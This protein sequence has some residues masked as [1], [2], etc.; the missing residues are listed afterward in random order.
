MLQANKLAVMSGRNWGVNP[1]LTRLWYKTVAERKICYAASTWAE[2]LNTKKIAQLSSIQRLFTLRIT[3]AYRTAPSSALLILSGLPPLHLTVKK[4]AI[5]TN[6]TRLGKNDKFGST[7]FNTIEYDTQISQW[8]EPPWSKPSTTLE[9]HL[10]S[11]NITI[12][13]DGSKIN[14]QMGSAFVAYK[15]EKEIF[16]WQ[17]KL[18]NKN[19]VYQ[20]EL[21]AIFKALQWAKQNDFS[22]ISIKTDSMSS[23]QAIRKFFNKNHLVQKIRN[24]IQELRTKQISIEWIKAHTGI[25]GNERADFLAKDATTNPD[26]FLESLP[27]PKSYIRYHLKKLFEQQWQEEWDTATTGRRTHNF[28]PKV[29]HKMATNL[30]ITY[31]VTGHGP[32]P[33]YLNRFGITEND[34]C[35]CGESGTPDHYLFSCPMT[36][37]NHEEKPPSTL[38]KEWAI[39][40]AKNKIIKEK[41]L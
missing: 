6:V 33:N 21:L 37:F 1:K 31:F 24:I 41:K 13:T 35:L 29:S 27:T 18:N 30:L 38:Y 23:I 26:S 4:E 36:D 3:R 32:F 7:H 17:G 12:Y 16:N 5:I 10:P 14:N 39:Q 40:A 22:K 28:L 20:A 2:N 8:T 34:L 19:S 11:S 25:M 9:N 15:T